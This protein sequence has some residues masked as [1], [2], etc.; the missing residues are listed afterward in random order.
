MNTWTKIKLDDFIYRRI[1]SK[2]KWLIYIRAKIS[3]GHLVFDLVLLFTFYATK[4]LFS[5]KINRI[6]LADNIGENLLLKSKGFLYIVVYLT[7]CLSVAW[8]LQVGHCQRKF[9]FFW[10]AHTY[11]YQ[12]EHHIAYGHKKTFEQWWAKALSVHRCIKSVL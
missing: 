1:I 9:V 10:C 8:L 5:Y 2:K 7:V 12:F 4:S 3:L 11:D 6:H